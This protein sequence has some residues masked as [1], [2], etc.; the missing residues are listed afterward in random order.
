MAH[1]IGH[2]LGMTH[3]FIDRGEYCKRSEDSS[4]VE[5]VQCKNWDVYE[6]MLTSVDNTDNPGYSNN[7]GGCCTGFMD[8]GQH[9]H[10]WSDCSVREFQDWAYGWSDC[11]VDRNYNIFTHKISLFLKL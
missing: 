4:E 6:E 9:P 10:D 11:M 8:Y 3:D 7:P 1:E 5:C 2:A